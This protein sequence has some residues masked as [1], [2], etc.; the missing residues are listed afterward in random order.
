LNTCDRNASFLLLRPVEAA[1][2]FVSMLLVLVV[3]VVAGTIKVAQLPLL[4]QT[5]ILGTFC[6]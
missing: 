2:F 6:V 1:A 5:F 3:V 4:N